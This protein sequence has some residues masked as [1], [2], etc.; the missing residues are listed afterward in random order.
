M[1]KEKKGINPFMFV[2]VSLFAAQHRVL[3]FRYCAVCVT[4]STDLR[5]EISHSGG[6]YVF[7][8]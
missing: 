7:L 1:T 6:L 8:S 3:S 5:V 2:Y 4:V